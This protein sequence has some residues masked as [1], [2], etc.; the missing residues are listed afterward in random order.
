MGCGSSADVIQTT[1]NNKENKQEE[2]DVKQKEHDDKSVSSQPPVN[3]DVD[4][5]PLKVCSWLVALRIYVAL[6]VGL[7]VVLRIYVALAV[8]QPYRDLEAGDN[9]SLKIQFARPRIE[10]LTSYYAC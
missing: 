10:L 4:P 8:F 3:N 2:H 7:W 5:T 6:S 9:Q 1:E